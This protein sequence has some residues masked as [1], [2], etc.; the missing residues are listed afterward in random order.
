MALEDYRADMERCTRCSYCKWIPLDHIKNWRF[1]AGC[2]SIEYGKFHAYS[3]SG[4]LSVALSFLD[5]RSSYTDKFLDIVFKCQMDGLC[6]VSDKICRYNM[7]PLQI[8]RE[9][10]HKLVEDGQIL[11]QHLL[12]I[13]NLRK[14]DNMMLK[15]KSERGEWAEG[16]GIK[17]LTTDKAEVLFHAGCR[18][19]YDKDLWKVTR[20]AINLLTGAGLDIGILGKDESCC[21]GRAF[22]IGFQSELTKFCEHN[23]EAWRQAGIK[24]IVTSCSDCYFTFK[25]LYPMIGSEFEVL[26][27]VELIDRLVK[28]GKIKLKNRVPMKVTYHDPCHLGRLG[29][30]Y[31]PWNGR[32]KKI[33]GQMV[34]YE[35]PKP[36]YNGVFGVY[37]P[38]RTLLKNIPGLELVEMPRRREFAWCCGAGGGVIDA[39]PEFS[40]QT[41]SERIEEAEFTGAQAIVSACPWCERNFSDAI[42]NTQT[43]S[44]KMEVFD[45]VEL[46]SKAL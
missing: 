36:R 42:S 26:H 10:R 27:T 20:T 14:E 45:I 25:R 37:E 41:A 32:E 9:L 23:V 13:E 44:T 24:T 30:P 3:A 12:V 21:G 29:E 15:P 17:D 40:L 34:V 18:F 46:V 11:P 38:P 22:D 35:P 19:S 33:F 4:R 2:P 39:Y 1:A 31:V 5:G 8:M 16:L 28:E 7:E 6:D 43:I